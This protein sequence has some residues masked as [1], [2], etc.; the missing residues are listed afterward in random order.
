MPRI[1]KVV[2]EIAVGREFDYLVPDALADRVHIGSRVIVPFG[3]SEARGFVVGFADKSEHAA[4]KEIRDVIGHKPLI[5]EKLL[6]LARWMGEYYA[7]PVEQ[8]VHTVLPGAV[9]RKGAGFKERLFVFPT[10]AASDVLAVEKL[11]KRAP[12]QAAALDLLLTGESMFLHHLARVTKTS[13][14]TIRSLEEKGFVRIGR[15]AEARDPTAGQTILRTEPLKLMSQ[16]EAAFELVKKSIDTRQPPVVL[17]YGVT[18]SGKTEVYLQALDYALKQGKGAVILVPEISLTPQ[19]V[20]RFKGR[21]GESIAVLHSHLSQGE[22]HD[23]WHRIHEGKARIAIGARSAVF[24]PVKDLGLIVVDEEHE[25][26][27]KQEEAPRYN[28]RDVAVM[29]GRMEAC[30]VVLGS[31]TPALESFYNTKRGKYGL[32]ELPHRVDHRMMPAVRVVDMR[33]QAQK[34]GRSHVLSSDL[35]EAI[36]ARLDRAEQTILFLNRRGFATS[37]V[38]PKCGY[39]AKC[40]ACSVSLTFHR[41]TGRLHCHICGAA[42]S[43]PGRCPNPECRDPSF[44]YAGVGTQKV[45]D[46]V[47]RVFPHARVHRMDADTTTRK[48]SHGHILGDFRTGKIDI[49]VGTQ[50]IAKGLHFPNVTLVGV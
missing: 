25:N 22:R 16:Q 19:T 29:R 38:C 27:Y 12:K 17:L 41:A 20:E 24:A 37:L 35:V 2:V 10:A 21:F 9:R 23:E 43:V 32:A 15:E 11:R 34:E 42:R 7:A 3:R 33:V 45:E 14:Q 47:Q 13:T 44:R 6:E 50:M 18:G 31:A 48:G 26:S 4:L 1:A 36:G 8:A 40:D 5:G 30:A 39:V 28:A 46:V 49:L